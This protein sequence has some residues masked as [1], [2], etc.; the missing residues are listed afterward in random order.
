MLTLLKNKI[1]GGVE[2]LEI[3]RSDGCGERKSVV[4]VL[5]IGP[6]TQEI[7]RSYSTE[8]CT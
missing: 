8:I 1:K 2:N 3:K 6:A 5:I 7:C 4:L